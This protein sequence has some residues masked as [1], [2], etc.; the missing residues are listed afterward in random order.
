M[1]PL[2]I[3]IAVT[4]TLIVAGRFGIAALR[5][6][7]NGLRGG[8]A[9]MFTAT[10]LAHFIGMRQELIAMVPPALPSPGLLVTITGVLELM[11]VAGLLWQRQTAHW[12]AIGLTVQLVAMFPANV[13]AAIDHQSTA[14]EDQL[15]PRT[16]M[17]LVFLAAT[18]TV[19]ARTRRAEIRRTAVE[20]L[21]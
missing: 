21:R 20:S 17:Q 4:L 8:L 9:A 7:T 10:G 16:I 2:V 5:D 18:G 15:V 11:G 13:Y 12:T 19:A 6:P 14:F 1:A 3:L